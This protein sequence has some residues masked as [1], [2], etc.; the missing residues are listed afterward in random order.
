MIIE[1]PEE[2]KLATERRIAKMK[3]EFSK[4]P[5]LKAFANREGY[6]GIV[7]QVCIP[8]LALCEHHHCSFEGLAAIAYIPGTHLLGL[9]KLARVVE[10]YLNPT[11]KTLQERA[12]TKILVHLKKSLNPAGLMVVL[13]AKH[14]CVAYRGVR[15]PSLTITSEVSGIFATDVGAR[16]EFLSLINS[17]N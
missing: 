13:K 10:Y 8:F 9:S 7:A 17:N 1:Q 2:L 16:S 6:K 11:V 14:S 15:K 3:K 5:I 12:T 4:A